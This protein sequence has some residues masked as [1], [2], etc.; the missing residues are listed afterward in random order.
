MCSWSTGLTSVYTIR[1]NIRF[2]MNCH[3]F[4]SLFFVNYFISRLYNTLIWCSMSAPFTPV[5]V[6]KFKHTTMSTRVH[7]GL[8]TVCLFS[9]LQSRSQIFRPISECR[10]FINL[11]N[12]GYIL[13]HKSFSFRGL[14]STQIW[15]SFGSQTPDTQKRSTAWAPASWDHVGPNGNQARRAEFYL[16]FF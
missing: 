16:I 7:R 11:A 8:C 10:N 1:T 6:E 2:S 14:S 12:S 9:L 4:Q 13:Y 15:R 3:L 5:G